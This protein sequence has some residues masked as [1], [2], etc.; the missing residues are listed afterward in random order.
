MKM[1]PLDNSTV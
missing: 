1:I